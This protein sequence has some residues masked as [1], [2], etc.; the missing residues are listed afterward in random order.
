M[1]RMHLIWSC[2]QYLC[3]M[4]EFCIALVWARQPKLAIGVGNGGEARG[5]GLAP[6][7]LQTRGLSPPAE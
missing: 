2:N 4:H 3:K 6:P 7:G 1:R 5:G